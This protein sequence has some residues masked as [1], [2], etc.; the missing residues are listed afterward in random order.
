ML[1]A[2]SAAVGDHVIGV[3]LLLRV[4]LPGIVGVNL[5]DVSA[6]VQQ[7][8]TKLRPLVTEIAEVDAEEQ[9]TNTEAKPSI[10]NVNV[11]HPNNRGKIRRILK[12]LPGIQEKYVSCTKRLA[13]FREV[14]YL[15]A[16]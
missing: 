7:P 9:P 3:V 2:V 15:I 6:E 14:C 10:S 13:F 8:S 11:I 16:V 12:T 5:V 4:I 1:E